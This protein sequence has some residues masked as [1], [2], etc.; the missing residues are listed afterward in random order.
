MSQ[1]L[2]AFI[3]N[4]SDFTRSQIQRLIKAG[5]VHIDDKPVSQGAQKLNGTESVRVDGEL[6]EPLSLRYLMLHK[7]QG[8]VCANTDS[9]HP[10]VLDLIDLPRKQTLQIAGRLDLDTT[11]LVLLTDDGQWNHRITSPRRE[12]S[13]RYRV[14]TAEPIAADT[15]HYFT[16]GI[17][18]HGEKHK[19][20]PA[21]LEL[22]DDYNAWLDIHEG[23][24]HQV[25]RMFAATGNKVI[26]L[27]RTR[28]GSIT[29]DN[30]LT[31]AHWRPLTPA[32]ILGIHDE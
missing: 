23:K 6:I 2:D 30:Q 14:T 31:P 3:S 10:T 11:G 32:E 15:A 24:Y 25:K 12:C 27:H 19:T 16:D 21:H 17:Q 18:L 4:N 1:R 5:R 28:I 8:Y 13:K 22:I 7:P 26:A 20:R 29:L 9:E